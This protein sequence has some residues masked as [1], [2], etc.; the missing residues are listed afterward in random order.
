MLELHT[1]LIGWTAI[2][3]LIL[4]F[5]LRKVAWKPILDAIDERTQ[6]INESLAQA[7]VAQKEAERLRNEYDK[8]MEKARLESQEL[9]GKSRKTAE[10]ARNEIVQKAQS[11]AEAILQR[12]KREISLE[13]EKALEEIKKTAGEV[14]IQIAAKIIGKSLNVKEHQKLI[15]QTLSELR[16]LIGNRN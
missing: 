15:Q 1:G 12:T 2:I 16:P 8:I 7:D 13:R 11:D 5:I 10:S 4:V 6:K 9:I 3:F 14:S